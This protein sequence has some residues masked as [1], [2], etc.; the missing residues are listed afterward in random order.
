MK[1]LIEKWHSKLDMPK[2]D[3]VWHSQDTA[4][5]IQELNEAEGLICKWSELSDVVYTCTRA[6]WS[7][8]KNIKF[9]YNKLKFFIGTLYMIPKY[10]LRWN[11]FR[12]LGKKFN[13]DLKIKEVRNPKKVKKLE[14][15]AIQYNLDPK[16][17]IDEAE[18]LMRFWFFLK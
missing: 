10:T 11:F 2:Y 17:F 15:I 9:P 12:T 6:N 7:G 5:E 8:H 1:K 4:D 16:I 3:F 14:N 13:K 18:K